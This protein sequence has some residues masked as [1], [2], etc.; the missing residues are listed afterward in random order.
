MNTPAKRL[1]IHVDV[2]SASDLPVDLLS[3]ASGISKQRIKAAMNKGAVWVT[4]G[5]TTQRLRRAKRTLRKGDEIHLYYDEIVL[6]MAPPEP[7]LLADVGGYSV[8]NKPCGLL[9]QGSKWGDHCTVVRWAEQQLQPQRPAFTVHR[10]DRATNGII[11]VA[12]SRSMAATLS[13]L[14]KE[15]KITKRYRAIVSGNLSRLPNPMRIEQ[16]VDKKEA[17]SEISFQEL[18][19]DGEQSL[20]DVRIETGRKHQIRRHLAELG[21]PIVGDRLYGKG[22]LDGVDLQLSAYL[23]AFRCPVNNRYVEYLLPD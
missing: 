18:L 10:L 7:Q 19:A 8:W 21:H 22:E 12:H 9:S 20:I 13:A 2:K 14:F 4:R 17:V 1:E 11:M 23:L 15:R 5:K 3:E 6:A 16:T